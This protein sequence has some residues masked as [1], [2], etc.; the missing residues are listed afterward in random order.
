M[1][2]KPLDL[3][4]QHDGHYEAFALAS[5]DP[6]TKNRSRVNQLFYHYQIEARFVTYMNT[7]M[8]RCAKD[9]QKKRQR[10][11]ESHALT[12]N[13]SVGEDLTVLDVMTIEDTNPAG[14]G[15]ESDPF[16][17]VTCPQ[18]QTIISRLTVQ[19]RLILYDHVANQLSFREIADKLGVSQQSTS[20]SFHRVMKKLRKAY[21]E[22][23]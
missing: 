6:T 14:W 16:E 11:H 21:Q 22:G 4:L 8:W 3:F 1:S 9:Y 20:K 5:K 2:K 12:L 7:T 17:L 23:E 10:W 18:L 13:Q 15:E 19:Q